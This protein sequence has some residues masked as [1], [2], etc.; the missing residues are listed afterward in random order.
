MG[1]NGAHTVHKVRENCHFLDHPPTP[2][3]LRDIKM[4]PNVDFMLRQ[5][6]ENFFIDLSKHINTFTFLLQGVKLWNK[7][8][9]LETR[10]TKSY[11]ASV[12]SISNK[13]IMLT[14]LRD[15]NLEFQKITRVNT[16]LHFCCR[17]LNFGKKY[18]GSNWKKVSATLLG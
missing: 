10:S 17:M 3:S 14:G 13:P 12:I 16:L 11:L 6:I 8:R 15:E 7:V 1:Y 9:G 5:K 18:G 4:A 2:M